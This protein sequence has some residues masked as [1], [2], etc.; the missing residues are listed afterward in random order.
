MTEKKLFI[1][2]LAVICLSVCFATPS[3]KGKGHQIISTEQI[4]SA[5]SNNKY[6]FLLGTYTME[7]DDACS[8]KM[9]LTI[10]KKDE[11]YTYHLITG[12]RDIKGIIKI[13]DEDDELYVQLPEVEWSESQSPESPNPSKD[14][15]GADFYYNKED[16][17]FL[18]Q[19]YGD[20]MNYFV[21]FSECSDNKYVI[22]KK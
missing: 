5:E 2:L 16:N 7:E 22:L 20:S 3:Q 10:D 19:N 15:F 17:S 12:K 13:L 11:E 9:K 1:M 4:E 14:I 18:V 21:I 6:D 8:C